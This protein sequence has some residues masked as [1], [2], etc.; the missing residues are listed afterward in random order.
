M[1][2]ILF[3]HPDQKLVSIYHKYLSPHFNVDSAYDGLSGLRK[4]R[5]TAPK[6]IV[7]EY[8]LPYLSGLTLLRYVRRYPQFSQTPFFFLSQHEMPVK[9]LGLGAN[10]WLRTQDHGPHELL[11]KI[12]NHF[13]YI[14][15]FKH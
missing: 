4:I 6:L 15:T 10:Q 9:A 5:Q 7:S 8:K 14:H 12:V 13:N 1:S 2:H 3:I 11:S